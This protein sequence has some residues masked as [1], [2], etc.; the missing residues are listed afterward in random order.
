MAGSTDGSC[1][2]FKANHNYF[3]HHYCRSSLAVQGFLRLITK[4]K[5]CFVPLGQVGH[6]WY[7]LY[8]L[9]VAF[10]PELAPLVTNR[11]GRAD[12]CASTK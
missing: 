1:I 6:T 3:R 5:V 12:T 10:A 4:A 9:S 11:T 2:T 7:E 8:L